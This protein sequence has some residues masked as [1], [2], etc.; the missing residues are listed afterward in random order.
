MSQPSQTS[1]DENRVVGRAVRIVFVLL[2]A[3]LVAAA[4]A[5]DR[6]FFER[7]V[8]LPYYYVRPGWLP[9]AVR[10]LMVV[11]AVVLAA[12]VG[13]ALAR[14][15]LRPG[16]Q[17]G[18]VA[19]AAA[20]LLAALPASELVLRIVEPAGALARSPRWEFKVGALHPRYGWMSRPARASTARDI[21]P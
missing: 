3:A 9:A 1:I 5:A 7:H 13:P 6:P 14:G 8:L 17:W 21:H 4:I 18:G 12:V 15:A 10:A 11:A 16:W 19:R 2:G 20:A